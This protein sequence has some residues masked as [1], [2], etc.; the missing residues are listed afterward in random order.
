MPIPLAVPIVAGVVAAGAVALRIH[1]VHKAKAAGAVNTVPAGTK[2]PAQTPGAA[3]KVVPTPIVSQPATPAQV[4]SAASAAGFTVDQ[5]AA[6]A[7]AAGTTPAAV[8]G[9]ALA[10]GSSVADAILQAQNAGLQAQIN[11]GQQ[12]QLAQV[13]TND[14]APSGDL[15]I[16]DQPNGTQIG[17]A[18]K[19]G[20]VTV[21]NPNVDGTFAQISWPGG[22]RL[23]AATGFA[24]KAF[25]KLI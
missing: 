12:V 10:A 22:S 21:I 1:A 20:M 13:T 15:I 19:D 23:P 9:N 25:L 7:A 3:P 11:P 5:V 2:V 17:G 8:V 4:A 24:R 6:A 14:P 16:R 18:E